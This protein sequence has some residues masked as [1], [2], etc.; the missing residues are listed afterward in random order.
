MPCCAMLCALSC[1]WWTL[2]MS[3]WLTLLRV[4]GTPWPSLLT[5]R[6]TCGAGARLYVFW[7]WVAGGGITAGVSYCLG[8]VP[9]QPLGCMLCVAV[10]VLCFMSVICH[11]PWVAKR[12][13]CSVIAAAVIAAAVVVAACCPTCLCCCRGEYGRLGIGDR[14]GSSKLRPH[15]VR[16]PTAAAL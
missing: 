9:P 5:D 4:G 6:S 11:L 2:R 12:W 10:T 13:R 7:S 8:C 1:R 15:K 16:G 3:Q 14:T